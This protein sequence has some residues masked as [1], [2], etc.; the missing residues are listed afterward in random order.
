MVRRI[1]VVDVLAASKSSRRQSFRH[2]AFNSSNTEEDTQ[3][4]LHTLCVAG[5]LTF[6]APEPREQV[7]KVPD[8]PSFASSDTEE[9]TQAE[10]TTSFPTPKSRPRPSTVKHE[11]TTQVDD[12]MEPPRKVRRI[13][14]LDVPATPKSPRRQSSRHAAC[15]SSNTPANV[16]SSQQRRSSDSKSSSKKGKDKGVDKENQILSTPASDRAQG[17]ATPQ[18]Y[19]AFK[20]RG[21]YAKEVNSYEATC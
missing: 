20:G 11:N 6:P 12:P 16:S 4:S 21:R 7:F 10:Y 18:D 14:V 17:R 13:E 8:I 3:G 15:N 2:A 5:I 19:S 9:D 1:E